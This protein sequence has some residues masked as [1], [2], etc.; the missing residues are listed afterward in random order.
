MG[1]TLLDGSGSAGKLADIRIQGD[2]IVAIGKI[3]PIAG[4]TV[5]DA[6]GMIVSPGFIDAHSHALGGIEN[7][8][9]AI[10]QV[11]QGIT[12]AVAGQDGGWSKPVAEEMADLLR[13]K[14]AI[15]FAIFS[16][17][18]GIRRKVMGAD[19]KR[20]ANASELGTMRMLVADDMR[21]GALGLSSGLEYDPGYYSNTAELVDLAKV[22]S[23]YGGMYISHVRDEGNK[24]F[25]AFLE[26]CQ[27]SR[28][29]RIR[30]QISHI[31][32]GT[33]PVWGKADEVEKLGVKERITA[34]VYPY[35]YWHSTISAL[36]PS[37]DWE[38]DNIWVAALE[39]VGGPQNVRLVSYTHEPTWVG[40][41]LSEIAQLTGKTPIALIQEILRR[42]EGPNGSGS[43]HVVVTA[44]SDADL[45]KFI[46]SPRTMFCSD[47]AIGGRHPRGAGS[48][49]RILGRYVRERKVIS[50]PEAIRK[51]T[52]LPARTFRLGKR[53][54]LKK[55]WFADVVI[56]D[57]A[58]IIDHSTPQNPT[59]LSEGVQH[60]F[61]NG[62]QVL[63]SGRSTGDRPGT[64]VPRVR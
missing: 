43:Q 39:E 47:G 42:T 58:K 1:G 19:Y 34:D 59:A 3:K 54:E 20:V 12:T 53:G 61:V 25:N 22:A 15:N 33:K 21:A 10:S 6:T 13:F 14:P 23:S 60:L 64:F 45:D 49:P 44:M 32:L 36:S 38:N 62:V 40:K 4:E 5:V 52:S 26:L 51:M 8:P 50:L 9:T 16:G 37:R 57:P 11:T 17:H 46:A 7:E 35:L 63:K 56:F 24:A 41:D 28:E 31:K 18:G 2:R 55:G 48:F 27:I 29:A 30:A